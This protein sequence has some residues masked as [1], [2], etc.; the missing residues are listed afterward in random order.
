MGGDPKQYQVLIDPVK[1]RARGITIEQVIEAV[2]DGVENRG[3]GFILENGKEAPIRILAR[4]PLSTEIA[5]IVVGRSSDGAI[6]SVEDIAEVIFAPDP[7]RRGDATVDGKAAVLLRIIKQNE[8]NTLDITDKVDAV[9]ES[10]KTSVPKGTVL[11]DDIFRQEWFINAG[12]SNVEEAL[13]DSIIMVA[14]IVTLFLMNVRA[15]LVTLVSLP[16]SL[17]VTFIIFRY[18]GTSI[19]VMTLGGLAVAVG[20]LVDDAIV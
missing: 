3:G 4:T 2:G 8:A 15:T 17:L 19:N 10:L 1:A 20:E 16:L 6:V 18:L 12:L 9:V 14:I 11:R 5:K 13:R 7:N